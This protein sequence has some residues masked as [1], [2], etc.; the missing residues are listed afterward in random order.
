MSSISYT[1]SAMASAIKGLQAADGAMRAGSAQVLEATVQALGGSS[2][3]TDTVTFSDASVE[4]GLL[5]V[6][7]A[8][9]ASLANAAVVRSTDDQFESMLNLVVPPR[10]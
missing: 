6:S 7:R 10:R 3:D 5:D 4:D 8:R 2:S 1:A 9:Y